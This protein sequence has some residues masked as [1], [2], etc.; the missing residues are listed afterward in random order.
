MIRSHELS[1]SK[2]G[3]TIMHDS[4]VLTVFSAANF[5]GHSN[6][7]GGIVY[8]HCFKFPEYFMKEFDS[9]SL[10]K[11]A[12]MTALGGNGGWSDEASVI[13]REGHKQREEEW[14]KKELSKL[15]IAIVEMKP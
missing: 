9:V 4:K 15:M 12:E 8:L 5:G 1:G 6:A 7:N 2:A 13:K 14:W 3:W 11:I 10:E